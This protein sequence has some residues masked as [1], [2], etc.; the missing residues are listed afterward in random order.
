MMRCFTYASRILPIWDELWHGVGRICLDN[1]ETLHLRFENTA[2]L[3]QEGANTSV[4]LRC[5]CISVTPIPH[6]AVASTSSDTLTSPSTAQPYAIQPTT[7]I[8]LPADPS[9]PYSHPPSSTRRSR[10]TTSSPVMISTHL[11]PQRHQIAHSYL[12]NPAPTHRSEIRYAQSRCAV[13]RCW[14]QYFGGGLGT[15]R[16]CGAA[17]LVP[18][19]CVLYVQ[20][21]GV[22]SDRREEEGWKEGI[23]MKRVQC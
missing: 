20:N 17:S 22:W 14:V 19:M 11:T 10:I 8:L 23:R 16:L 6:P 15:I 5:C 12:T 1:D 2:N 3:G 13:P 9:P 7:A 18:G 21:D 4:P